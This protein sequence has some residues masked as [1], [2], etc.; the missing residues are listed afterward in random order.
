[1]TDETTPTTTP[2]TTQT[3]EAP[4]AAKRK[5]CLWCVHEAPDLR[6]ASSG[7]PGYVRV[8]C[9]DCGRHWHAPT[10]PAALAVGVSP[11]AHGLTPCLPEPFAALMQDE[12]MAGHVAELAKRVEAFALGA[13]GPVMAETFPAFLET[14]TREEWAIVEAATGL[15]AA[16]IRAAVAALEGVPRTEGVRARRSKG[17]G[18]EAGAGKAERAQRS[19]VCPECGGLARWAGKC[20]C[21]REV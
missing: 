7:G 11:E 15:D 10:V 9:P 14:L 19:H 8:A 13:L 21:S 16:R 3:D 1:M 6:L 12:G 4:A 2:T 5:D 18:V 17:A 20:E